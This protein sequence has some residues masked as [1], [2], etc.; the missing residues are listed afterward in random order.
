MSIAE[1]IMQGTNR[2]SESTAW[3]GDSLAKLGQ[4]VGAALAQR[5]QQKQAQEMLA[6]LQQS[7]QESMTLAGSGKTGEAYAKL[8]PLLTDPS[9]ARNPFLMQ[10]IPALEN[11]IKIAADDFYKKEQLRIQEGMYNQ[12]SDYN[13]ERIR[14]LEEKQTGEETPTSD[15]NRYGFGNISSVD[16][17]TV[18]PLP[19]DPNFNQPVDEMPQGAGAGMPGL[20]GGFSAS[21]NEPVQ[22]GTPA[23]IAGRKNVEDVLTLPQ[24]EQKQASMSFGVTNVN[25]DQYEVQN[26]AGLS[27]YLPDF[28]GFAVPK[29]TWKETTASLSGKNQL[30]RQ[31]KLTAPEA[32][33]NFTKDGGT[34]ANVEKAV[35]TMGDKTMGKLFNDFGKDIYALRAATDQKSD[36]TETIFTVTGKDEQETEIT[37]D[38]YA[39]IETIA[40]ITPAVA[41]NAG[42][43]PAI[44]KPSSATEA[45]A[46]TQGRLPATQFAA[47]SAVEI[48]AEAVELQKIVEQG[49][50]AKAKET[51]KSVDKRIQ[52]IDA[53]IKRL[54]SPTTIAYDQAG[55]IAVE[56][57]IGKTPEEA[58][59][60]I[61]KIAQLKSEKELL[62]VKTEKAYNTAKSEGRVFQSAEEAKSSK[63]KFRAGT[64]IYIGREPAKVK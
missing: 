37:K 57:P 4:N 17:E 58:Q 53:Q 45:P 50:A 24:E 10:S 56:R 1:L 6:F 49:K 32:R 59:A 9:V 3:V 51:E 30:S 39:A 46:P 7:M 63:K 16:N 62:F 36:G 60:D 25:P 19:M 22:E 38:Q 34:K 5:E 42:G 35:R 15:A 18:T 44:F 23:Q 21:L 27:K 20:T 41:E 52:D 26:I 47:T 12:R 11:G 54:A 48:P 2:A 55:L 28:V 61:E 13:S 33:E 43:T 8:I 40:G 29:E 64:I 14:L 31:S